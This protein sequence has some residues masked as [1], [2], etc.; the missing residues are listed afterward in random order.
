MKARLP[1]KEQV[2]MRIDRIEIMNMMTAAFDIALIEG[3]GI[4]RKRLQRVHRCAKRIQHE[5]QIAWE[6]RLDDTCRAMQKVL[7][8]RKIQF[9]LHNGDSKTMIIA[10]EHDLDIM[11]LLL[12][13]SEVLK[14]GGVRCLRTFDRTL[15]TIR[16]TNRTFSGIAREALASMRSRIDGYVGAGIWMEWADDLA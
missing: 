10:K 6:G 1:K 9:K 3:H 4:G 15:E 16:Y 8:S 14:H 2:L 13:E 7:E 12:A 5:Y 11:I